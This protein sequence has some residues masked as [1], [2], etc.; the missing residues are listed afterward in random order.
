[1]DRE[2]Q[3]GKEGSKHKECLA[4]GEILASAVMDALPEETDSDTGSATE[5]DAG[6][7]GA[8]CASAARGTTLGMMVAVLLMATVVRKP[9]KDGNP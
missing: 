1:M 6:T 5:T 4:C 9:K 8:G 7:D 2:P 3:P